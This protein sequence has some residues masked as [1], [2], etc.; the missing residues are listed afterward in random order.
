V[1]A[2][3]LQPNLSNKPIHFKTALRWMGLSTVIGL[4]LIM[5]FLAPAAYGMGKMPASRAWIVP[6][7]ILILVVLSWGVAI[8]LSLKRPAGSTQF[9]VRTIGLVAVLLLIG[10]VMG[11][12]NTFSKSG[13]LGI[14]A[15]E[16]DARDQSLRLTAVN[17][18]DA[19]ITPFSVDMANFANLDVVDET[20]TGDYTVCMQD[21]YGLQ[22][23][24]IL[25]KAE[26]ST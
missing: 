3:R 5:A 12:L 18:G 1:M 22:S 24:T 21:Y 13:D 25:A 11:T 26:G 8:G 14:Y 16:W 2:N 4:I 10:P 17:G 20:A 9:S 6:Q 15:Q 7:T 19:T 23:V